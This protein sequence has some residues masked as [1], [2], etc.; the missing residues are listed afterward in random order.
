MVDLDQ[1]AKN[2]KP[3]LGGLKMTVAQFF[4]VNGGTTQLRGVVPDIPLQGGSDEGDF[5]E[6][7]FD[8]ALP[9]TQIKPA[10]YAP[11]AGVQPWLPFLLRKHEAREKTDADMKQLREAITQ[12]QLARKNNVLSLNETERRKDDAALDAQLAA[13]T[14]TRTS[15]T[16]AKADDGLQPDE[17]SVSKSLSAEKLRKDAKDIFLI[18][19]AH[20]M[21]DAIDVTNTEPQWAARNRPAA[22]ASPH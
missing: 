19:A 16:G 21:A 10:D 7:S 15:G 11:S 6:S 17:R 4:R 2:D 14:P 8:N 20:I 1:L 12:A 22:S 18:E 13:H 5:G 9:W 3:R